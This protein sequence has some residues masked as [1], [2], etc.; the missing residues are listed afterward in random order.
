MQKDK[1][2]FA[3]LKAVRGDTNVKYIAIEEV[4][5]LKVVSLLI[6]LGYDLAPSTADEW[7]DML[8]K[9]ATFELT[10]KDSIYDLETLIQ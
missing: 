2:T 6:D 4:V 5:E 1:T 10:V 3:Y 9:G 8:T 7:D